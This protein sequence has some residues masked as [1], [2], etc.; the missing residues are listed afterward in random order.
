M[1]IWEVYFEILS[2]HFG[3]TDKTMK[4]SGK[5]AEPSDHESNL[6][7]SEYETRATQT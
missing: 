7:P 4:I 5:M 1:M 6:E 3:R 2:K